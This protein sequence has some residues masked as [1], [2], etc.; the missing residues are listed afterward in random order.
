MTTNETDHFC[1]IPLQRA[2]HVLAFGADI[3]RS[4]W[5][6]TITVD[7][8]P[9][10]KDLLVTFL[11]LVHLVALNLEVSNSSKPV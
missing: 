11:V 6:C 2:L 4:E 7:F 8:S 1:V 10:S 5:T 9:C 3:R